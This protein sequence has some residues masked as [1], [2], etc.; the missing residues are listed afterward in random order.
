MN[1]GNPIRI[2][3]FNGFTPANGSRYLVSVGVTRYCNVFVLVAVVFKKSNTVCAG[4][5]RI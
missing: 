3:L 5:A 4:A 2:V 1:F